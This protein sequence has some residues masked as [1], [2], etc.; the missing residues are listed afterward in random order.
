M[1]ENIIE[2]IIKLG[3]D[4]ADCCCI[5]M[6]DLDKKVRK[7]NKI[8]DDEVF[9]IYFWKDN[10]YVIWCG[11]DIPLVSLNKEVQNYIVSKLEKGEFEVDPSFQG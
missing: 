4:M 2:K 8:D 7:K 6:N 3:Y 1:N 9:G 5:N 10:F 11:D